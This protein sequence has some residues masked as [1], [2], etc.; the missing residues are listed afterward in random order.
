MRRSYDLGLRVS[1]YW[2]SYCNRCHKDDYSNWINDNDS[3]H[4]AVM[5]RNKYDKILGEY[6]ENDADECLKKDQ[7][8]PETVVNGAPTFNEGIVSN[9]PIKLL[10][11]QKLIFDA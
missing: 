6:R 8:S 10:S 7:T 4:G 3:C 5:G 11:G 2:R 9:G 1:E